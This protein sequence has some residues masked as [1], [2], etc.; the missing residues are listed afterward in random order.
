MRAAIPGYV[1]SNIVVTRHQTVV[2]ARQATSPNNVSDLCKDQIV[3]KRLHCA[4]ITDV[5]VKT[6]VIDYFFL[7]V[8]AD[9]HAACVALK[10]CQSQ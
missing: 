4:L 8:Q 3:A 5:Y 1:S 9:S 7:Q 6:S 2:S 10:R